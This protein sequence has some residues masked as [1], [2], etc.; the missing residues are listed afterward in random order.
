M[1]ENLP[2]AIGGSTAPVCDWEGVF[3]QL[4]RP[5]TNRVA[6]C[7]NLVE[8]IAGCNHMRCE[9]GTDFCYQCGEKGP[10]F[11]C[12]CTT[13]GAG[14][15]APALQATRQRIREL[16]QN[17]E[18]AEAATQQFRGEALAAARRGGAD[19]RILRRHFQVMGNELHGD[20]SAEQAGGAQGQHMRA[21]T[22]APAE[23]YFTSRNPSQSS[24]KR[25]GRESEEGEGARGQG[26]A[27]S[28]VDTPMVGGPWPPSSMLADEQTLPPA[29]T[30][31]PNPSPVLGPEI[32][33]RIR[34]NER[35]NLRRSTAA[36][37]VLPN[38]DR[39][40]SSVNLRRSAWNRESEALRNNPAQPST[41]ARRFLDAVTRSGRGN[42]ASRA[43]ETS[44]PPTTENA[45]RIRKSL[46]RKHKRS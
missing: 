22:A 38:I 39:A 12:G 3:F 2:R 32:P 20:V 5:S 25:P 41:A 8:K 30:P 13:D 43:T 11:A 31:T 7:K 23:P 29:P 33:W 16:Y 36:D 1:I 4:K 18:R 46:S 14:L 24:L 9:C 37:T 10:G 42:N 35:Y 44:H 27:N 34:F 26:S 6:G 21:I 28:I 17:V 40:N 15:N 19:F 45:S